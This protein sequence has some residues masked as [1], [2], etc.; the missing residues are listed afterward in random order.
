[1]ARQEKE[2]SDHLVPVFG[3]CGVDLPSGR[4]REEKS[5]FDSLFSFWRRLKGDTI[6]FLWSLKM[7]HY[8]ASL[9][10]DESR[11]NERMFPVA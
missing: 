2:R 7:L 9:I 3:G 1:M 5:V 10:G 8:S 6:A 11:Y 4:R